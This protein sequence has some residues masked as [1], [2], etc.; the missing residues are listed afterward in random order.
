MGDYV[1]SYYYFLHDSSMLTKGTLKYIEVKHDCLKGAQ[2]N[3]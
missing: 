2:I 3:T 1:K